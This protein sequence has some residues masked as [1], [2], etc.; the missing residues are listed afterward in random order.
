M[1]TKDS[2]L[3]AIIINSFPFI[4]LGGWAVVVMLI[5]FS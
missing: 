1:N 3:D 4:Y 2:K 5:I